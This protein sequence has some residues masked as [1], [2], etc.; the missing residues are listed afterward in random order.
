MTE[1]TILPF[2]SADLERALDTAFAA[3]L[4]NL[5]PQLIMTLYDPDESP[6]EL[7]SLLGWFM[8]VDEWQADWSDAQ[9]RAAL[10]A[11]PRLH[12]IK[13]T[14]AAV[15]GA[16]QVLG[17]TAEIDDWHEHLA[18]ATW[19]AGLQTDGGQAAPFTFRLRIT[20]FTDNARLDEIRRVVNSNKRA[21]A[22][23]FVVFDAIAEV[24]NIYAA[25]AGRGEA[26]KDVQQVLPVFVLKGLMTASAAAVDIKFINQ[27]GVTLA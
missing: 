11:A 1:R 14:D 5:N 16:L 9:K 15:L 7:L 22:H 21:S 4:N 27:T 2:S 12:R 6:A 26:Y 17:V 13:G 19:D 3:R 10:R 24:A 20:D 25:A 18:D 8:S 23:Y